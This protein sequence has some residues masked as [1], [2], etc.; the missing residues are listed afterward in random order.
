MFTDEQISGLMKKKHLADMFS[1]ELKEGFNALHGM[2]NPGAVFNAAMAIMIY[3]I[4]MGLGIYDPDDP[5]GN[6]LYMTWWKV[7]GASM[8]RVLFLRPQKELQ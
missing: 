7:C 6:S 1:G 5:E 4:E 8:R 2:K 3:D